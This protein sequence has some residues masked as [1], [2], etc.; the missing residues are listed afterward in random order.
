MDAGKD[1]ANAEGAGRKRSG[2][3]RAV[4]D[5]LRRR[6]GANWPKI[7]VFV[8]ALY[9]LIRLAVYGAT[10]ALGAN[11]VEFITRSTGLWT[12]VFLCITLSV[13]PVRRLSGLNVLARFR[14]MI[15]LF[16]FFYAALHFLTYIW[17]DRWFDL[18]SVWH[19]VLKRPFITVGF[20]AFLIL[21]VLAATSPRAA[22]RRL[23]RRWQP[24]HRAIYAAAGLALLHFWWMKAGKNDLAQP[25]IYVFVVAVLLG[26]RL[27]FAWRQRHR[28][29][30]GR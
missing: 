3:A 15:G 5:T 18:G 20:G 16:T 9:P 17:L 8:A 30:A 1:I 24:L 7:G 22:V 2:A 6:W 13:T 12:L 26:L 10:G 25:R 27:W 21:C 19:D 23:G 29:T 11:P 14:R 4:P 28:P